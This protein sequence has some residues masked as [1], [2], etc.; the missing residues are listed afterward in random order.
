[1]AAS[2]VDRTEG[3]QTTGL[4]GVGLDGVSRRPASR[5]VV[6]TPPRRSRHG[7][8]ARLHVPLVLFLLATAPQ[9]D[10]ATPPVS[11][12]DGGFEATAPF[13]L[14]PDFNGDSKAD[15]AIGVPNEELEKSFQGAVSVIYGSSAGLT[16]DENQLWSQDSPGILDDGD[17]GDH[18]GASLGWADFNGDDYD[19]LAIGVPDEYVGNKESAGAVSII[20]GSAS[21]LA[22]SDNQFWTKASPGIP[23]D[24]GKF[25]SFGHSL[26]GRDFDGDGF[27]DLVIGTGARDDRGAG[28]AQVLFGS[29]SGLQTNG[30]QLLV[31]L[32]GKPERRDG[33]GQTFAAGDFDDDGF[34]D[35]AIGVDQENHGG[36]DDAGAVNVMYG[37]SSGLKKAGNQFWHQGSPGVLGEPSAEEWLGRALSVADFNGDGISNLA[38]GIIFD[39]VG[40]AEGAGSALVLYGSNDGLTSTGNQLW[41]QDVSGVIG[42]AELSDTTGDVVGGDFDADGFAD[43]AIGYHGE[44]VAGVDGADAV[45]VIYG[46][47]AGLSAAGNQIWHQGSPDVEDDLEFNDRFGYALTRADFDG[48]GYFDLAI[49]VLGE[50]T[51]TGEEEAGAVNVLYGTASGLSAAGDQLWKQDTFEVLDDSEFLDQFGSVLAER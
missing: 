26:I 5:S 48:D 28:A 23:D 6:G 17:I 50:S 49:G 3:R 19:D 20:Y 32:K 25:D 14:R 1:M 12:V 13:S 2:G 27:G 33:F 36:F 43:L 4:V 38:I 15:L 46:T 41:N 42:G 40:S 29:A 10:A 18:F 45:N 44:D 11:P 7:P 21:G 34:P 9:A 22:S 37:S 30:N 35:L 16:T 39:D 51:S 31:Q 8:Y 24:A 47:A